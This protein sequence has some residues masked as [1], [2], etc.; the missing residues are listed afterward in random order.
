MELL[1]RQRERVGSKSEW[2]KIE[3][4]LPRHAEALPSKP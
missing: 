2:Y 3:D 4:A 1:A